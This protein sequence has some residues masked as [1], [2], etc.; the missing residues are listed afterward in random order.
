MFNFIL[1]L[2]GFLAPFNAEIADK[3]AKLG[4]IDDGGLQRI[5][6]V[7]GP[8]ALHSVNHF[9]VDHVFVVWLFLILP[10]WCE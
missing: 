2:L 9:L 3:M 7:T 10:D 6:V 8:D 4:M 5:G 1:V